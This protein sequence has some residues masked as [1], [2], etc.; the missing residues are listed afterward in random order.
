[1]V[2]KNSIIQAN[3]LAHK[4][5]IGCVLQVDEVK[6]WGVVAYIKIPKTGLAYIRL[7][8]NTFNYIGE[9]VMIENE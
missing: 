3:E 1:M 2:K 8:N 5:W 6:S 4:D 9:A 7:I